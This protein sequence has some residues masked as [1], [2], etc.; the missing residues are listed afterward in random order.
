MPGPEGQQAQQPAG[1][2]SQ[3]DGQ[4]KCPLSGTVSVVLRTADS[5]PIETTV[6]VKLISKDPKAPGSY[7]ATADKG[8]AMFDEVKEGDYDAKLQVADDGEYIQSG[9]TSPDPVKAVKQQVKLVTMTVRKK[10]WIGFSVMDLDAKKTISNVKFKVTIPDKDGATQSV[11]VR[12][13]G[14]QDVAKI[15]KLKGEQ[16]ELE[17]VGTDAVLIFDSLESK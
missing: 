11:E 12:P 15:E 8:T 10:P 16:V 5:K 9:K 3:K 4:K 1:T 2:T 17:Q 13:V 7:T 6:N 14:D